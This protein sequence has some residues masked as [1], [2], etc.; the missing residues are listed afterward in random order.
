MRTPLLVLTFLTAAFAQDLVT[1]A[2]KNTKIEY[3]DARVRVVRLK[4][5]PHETLPMHDRPGRVVITLTANDVHLTMPDGKVRTTQVP[6]GNIAWAGPGKRLVSNLEQPVENI[7]VEMKNAA[8][9]AKPVAQL[10][11]SEDPRALIEPFHR[12]LFENQ[13][14][15]VY[16]VRIPPG[17]TTEFHRHAYDTVVVHMSGGLTSAQVQGGEW[18]KPA[19]DAA[20]FVEFLSDSKKTRIHRVHN[21]GKAEFHVVLVQL[22]Q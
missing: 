3:E 7:V 15:R 12:W 19:A 4:I 13:Y 9:P 6:A 17:G 2:P 8:D 14:V 20:G 11:S 10:P 1:V 22:M 18:G 16:D 21:D 5:A